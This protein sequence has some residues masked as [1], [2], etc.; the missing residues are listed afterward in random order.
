MIEKVFVWKTRIFPLTNSA[1]VRPSASTPG[2][3]EPGEHNGSAWSHLW[4]HLGLPKRNI[5]RRHWGSSGEVCTDWGPG[6]WAQREKSSNCGTL[7]LQ[8]PQNIQI[9]FW[10]KTSIICIKIQVNRLTDFLAVHSRFLAA[11][12]RL[13][14]LTKRI[15][16]KSSPNGKPCP[17]T[18]FY[19]NWSQ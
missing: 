11:L 5:K 4:R 9:I 17:K 19:Q 16:L 7:I 8:E 10:S 6:V 2:L 3:Q 18:S 12:R 14:L 15:P 1:L 13:F